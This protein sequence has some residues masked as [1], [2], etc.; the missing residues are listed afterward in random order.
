MDDTANVQKIYTDGSGDGRM[1]WYNETTG[2]SWSGKREGA[3]SNEAEYLAVYNALESAKVNDIEI[4][5]DSKLVVHQL[6]REWHIK[7]DKMRELFDKVQ[8][9][10]QDRGLNVK[11]IWIPREKNPAGKYLG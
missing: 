3:T 5:S 11:F 4:V 9:L 8:K 1:A 6:K 2:E 7:D 10:I